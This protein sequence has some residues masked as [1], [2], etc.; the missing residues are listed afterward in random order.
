MKRWAKLLAGLGVC[1]V[2]TLGLT[3]SSVAQSAKPNIIF[4]LTDD[5]RADDLNYMPKTQAAIFN[6]GIT[7]DDFFVTT[8]ECCPS[9]STI[10]TGNYAHNTG[11]RSNRASKSKVK[12]GAGAFAHEGNP[13][14]TVAV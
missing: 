5:M 10:L 3:S 6:A 14:H 2:F 4:I 11:V 9:R 12:G 8:S 1:C 13:S 7:Y